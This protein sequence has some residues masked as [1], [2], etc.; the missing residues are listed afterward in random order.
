[1]HYRKLLHRGGAVGLGICICFSSVSF[2]VNALSGTSAYSETTA[3]GEQSEVVPDDTPEEMPSEQPPSLPAEPP[4]EPPEETSPPETTEHPEETLPPEIPEETPPAEEPETPADTPS[5]DKNEGPTGTPSTE[6][7]TDTP[8]S[9]PPIEPEKKEL[10]AENKSDYTSNDALIQDQVII[11]AP[12]VEE[13]FRF[14]TVEKVYGIANRPVGVYE[15]MRENA[16]QVGT[17]SEGDVC[18]ILKNEEGWGYIESGVVRG[19][20][21][22]KALV[23]GDEAKAIVDRKE[24][25]YAS[26]SLQLKD[27]QRKKEEIQEQ[28]AE[29][30]VIHDP[31]KQNPGKR[32]E[33]TQIGVSE[34][35][36]PDNTSDLKVK[37]VS[38]AVA[39]S[40]L[41]RKDQG[42]KSYSIKLADIVSPQKEK[43]TEMPEANMK[44]KTPS[45]GFWQAQTSPNKEM[46]QEAA[47]EEKKS[48]SDI[49]LDEIEKKEKQ[50]LEEWKENH[51]TYATAV[52]EPIQN[53]A[54]AY[55]RTTTRSTVVDKVSAVAQEDVQILAEAK[56]DAAA[57]GL[58]KK[59]GISYVLA[60]EEKEW[61]YVES[62]D[63]RG[64]IPKEMLALGTEADSVITAVGEENMIMAEKT[65]EPK[66][67]P[68]LYYTL[69]SIKEGKISS[70]IRESVMNFARQFIGNPYVWGG[71]SLTN[72]ADCSGFVQTIFNTYYGYSLP[73]VAED[74]AQ[75]GEKIRVEDALP[76]DLIFYAKA[77]YI[78]HV[79]MYA[80]DGK[81]IEA[82]STNTGIVEGTVN[83]ADAVWATRFIEDT[84][85]STIQMVNQKAETQD[86]V[87]QNASEEQLGECLGNFKLTA[88][89]NC[90]LCCGQ[91]AGGPT[92]SGTEPAQGRTVAV[93]GIPFGTQLVINGQVYTVEDRGTPY[94]HIDIYMNSHEECD[95]FGVQSAEVYLMK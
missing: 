53:K 24:E 45:D 93:G 70:A 77:G 55:T 34:M 17:L 74:Q 36:C 41:E 9:E 62:G 4:A 75:Y 44:E 80:G 39:L 31:V 68:A 23:T 52:V 26:Y 7:I 48:S 63:V 13:D 69:T 43:V 64:F 65:V 90:E 25:K 11:Q 66:D 29:T 78:Y 15:E 92:A 35:K 59:D 56:E 85:T 95:Q 83:A 91:W 22:E 27:I 57:V 14:V 67:N 84:D 42:L 73:R 46:K 76:G 94:G 18:F 49:A 10:P 58:L 20:V 33:G 1:M 21:P 61:V 38:Y 79:V 6:E 30:A 28:Q 86:A 60:D 54:L 87:I 8:S 89:C 5:V 16:R 51:V 37:I 19:F 72:G 71:T 50:L 12:Q 81:T 88:Y 40:D 2:N 82:Q 47:E 32:Q 3:S